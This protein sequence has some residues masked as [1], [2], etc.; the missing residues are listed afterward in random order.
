MPGL[1]FGVF[2]RYEGN[3]P[4]LT[5][6]KPTRDGKDNGKFAIE[7]TASHDKKSALPG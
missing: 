7:Q 1:G 2:V 5:A 3:N 6:G 4:L